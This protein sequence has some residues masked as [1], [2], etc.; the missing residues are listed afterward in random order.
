VCP[1]HR[2]PLE[3]E[4]SWFVGTF[5][6]DE[7]E[8]DAKSEGTGAPT[9]EADSAAVVA[10]KR[11]VEPNM[12]VE[13]AAASEEPVEEALPKL[14][15]L[16][17]GPTAAKLAPVVDEP[18]SEEPVEDALPKLKALGAGADVELDVNALPVGAP[19]A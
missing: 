2:Q 1:L 7:G 5:A 6:S 11:E 8:E 18:K 15:A 17:A 10:P 9:E 3:V 4:G 16:G 12:P 14:K 13:G 19:D